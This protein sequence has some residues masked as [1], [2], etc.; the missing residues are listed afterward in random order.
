MKL[1][2]NTQDRARPLW[3]AVTESRSST[4]TRPVNVTITTAII[5]IRNVNHRTEERKIKSEA[6]VRFSLAQNLKHQMPHTKKNSFP[7]M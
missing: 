4:T 1:T 7:A 6:S 2:A 5:S 3:A